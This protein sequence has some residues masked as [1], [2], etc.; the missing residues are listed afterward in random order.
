MF[1]CFRVN[2]RQATFR[3]NLQVILM[4]ALAG[5]ALAVPLTLVMLAIRQFSSPPRNQAPDTTGLRV[6]LEQAAEKC[7]Q[8]PGIV[9]DGRAVFTLSSPAHALETRRAVEQSAKKLN[10]VV[11]SATA[12]REGGERLLV[13]IPGVGAHV[14][15]AEALRNFVQSQHGRP[16][17]ESR[18]YELILPAP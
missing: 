18:L 9:A 13:Q 1:A 2:F 3:V 14:F 8:P 4:I 15:E 10:G 16:A 7:W 11:L 5:I 17:G 12:G 6:A